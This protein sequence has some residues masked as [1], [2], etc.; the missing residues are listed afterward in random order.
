MFRSIKIRSLCA[1]GLALG[2]C[3]CDKALLPGQAPKAE[4][5]PYDVTLKLTPEAV[6]RLSDLKDTVL[7]AGYYYGMPTKAALPKANKI[8]QIELGSDRYSFAPT[9][10]KAHMP[11]LHI[12]RSRFGDI[13]DQTPYVFISVSS[14]GAAGNSDELLDCTHF[15]GTLARARSGPIEISCTLLPPLEGEDR[16]IP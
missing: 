8:H 15:R 12:D 7:I 11:G 3:Q 14:A 10:T 4:A 2:L 13:I 9:T 16:V 1:V 6:K 5:S